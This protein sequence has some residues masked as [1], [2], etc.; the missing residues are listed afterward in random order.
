MENKTGKSLGFK[1]GD[2]VFTGAFPGII[3]SDV[4]TTAPCCEVWGWEHET[5][6]AYASDLRKLSYPEWLILAERYQ[7]DGSAYSPVAQAAITSA[8]SYYA[9]EVK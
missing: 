9:T 3:V 8:T 5:G 1:K 7:F 6:S 4:N 2:F